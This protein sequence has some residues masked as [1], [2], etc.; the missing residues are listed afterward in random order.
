MTPRI[1]LHIHTSASDGKFSPE[2]IV[3]SS[4]KLGLTVIAICDHDSVGGITTALKTARGFSQ[5]RVIAGVEVSTY[6]PGSE[7]HLL[8]YFIDYTDPELKATLANLRSSRRQRAKRT[9]TK[10][11][12]LD[13]HI[14]WQRVQEIASGGSIGRPHIAQAMLEKGYITSL[15]EAFTK[16]I[17]P[18]GPAYIERQK[19]TPPEAV[20]LITKAGGLPVLAHPLT[21][22][23][24]EV[25][26]AELKTAGLV[27]LEVHYNGYTEDE[28]NSLARLAEKYDL[29]AT[30]GSDYHGLDDGAETMIG[31]TYV[32]KESAEKL[33]ALD[34]SQVL[35]LASS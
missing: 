5:I 4:A 30:G 9:I 14:S 33:I 28:R 31:G 11:K 19:I 13:V 22:N 23:D 10:L 26:I 21:V 16:Y 24:P 7:A 25:M 12:G 18:K 20:A 27:G 8:G 2:D 3:H 1:D 34:Q 15:K 29:I 32:P 17:G 6:A 35:K